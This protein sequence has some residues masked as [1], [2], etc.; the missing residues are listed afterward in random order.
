MP[1]S[2]LRLS[3]ST[4]YYDYAP[5]TCICMYL[6]FAKWPHLS[7]HI[8]YLKWEGQGCS[9]F[10]LLEAQRVGLGALTALSFLSAPPMRWI[11]Q[12]PPQTHTHLISACAKRVFY[13][14]SGIKYISQATGPGRD[15]YQW[16]LLEDGEGVIGLFYLMFSEPGRWRA[17]EILA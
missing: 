1:H 5:S 4:G 11:T 10:D 2:I 6:W 17:K 8:F 12:Q 9:W 7:S 15:L 14:S 13:T 16:L 3:L